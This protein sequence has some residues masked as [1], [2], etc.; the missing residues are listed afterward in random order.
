MQSTLI[1]A[2]GRIDYEQPIRIRLFISA[3]V[4]V[5]TTLGAFAAP[6]QAQ[7]S[8]CYSVTVTVNGEGTS[9]AGC[10]P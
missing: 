4:L 10:L 2:S 9:Q 3:G 6:A 7:V 8:A 5:L 1:P